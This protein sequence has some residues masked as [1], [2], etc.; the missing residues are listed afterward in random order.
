MVAAAS[1]TLTAYVSEFYEFFEVAR[2]VCD[3]CPRLHFVL[4]LSV[5]KCR[6]QQ[7]DNFYLAIR[8]GRQR[9]H[10]MKRRSLR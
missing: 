2:T 1:L 8:E 4:F 9:T 5:T 6:F 7:R 10:K 3:A